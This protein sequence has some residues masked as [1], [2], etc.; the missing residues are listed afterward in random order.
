MPR[1]GRPP[2]AQQGRQTRRRAAAWV[3]GDARIEEID[4]EDEKL[5]QDGWDFYSRQLAGIDVNESLGWRKRML[6]YDELFHETGP[7][8]GMDYN[9]H[10]DGDSTIAYAIQLAMKDREEQ[11]VDNALERVRRA[12]MSGQKNV[13]LSRR[14]LEALERK[15]VQAGGN[16]VSGRRMPATK[17]S[18]SR[19]SSTSGVSRRGSS[20]AQGG[21]NTSYQPADNS[22]ARNSDFQSRQPTSSPRS[23]LRYPDRYSTTPSKASL[24]GIIPARSL[25]DEPYQ[26][27]SSRDQP[28]HA[29]RSLV[30][31]PQRTSQRLLSYVSGYKVGYGRPSSVRGSSVAQQASSKFRPEGSHND[32]PS[33]SGDG[34]RVNIADVSERRVP[35]NSTSQTASGKGSRQRRSYR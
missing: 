35:T 1:W 32:E 5:L 10:E 19:V 27:S 12:Q 25:S 7:L 34:D 33:D 31:S 13:R 8:D 14:E 16:G 15:R 9:L 6:E 29:I 30:D 4:S 24:R 18:R 17:T 3:D 21:Q 28:S 23:S 26:L 20:Q 11:L 2:G 22:W